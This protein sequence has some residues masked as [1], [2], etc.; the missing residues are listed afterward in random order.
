MQPRWN[1]PNYGE[2][3]CVGK[4][5]DLMPD[6]P[7]VQPV[8]TQPRTTWP[9]LPTGTVAR[10]ALIV[11]GGRERTRRSLAEELCCVSLHTPYVLPPRP[12]VVPRPPQKATSKFLRLL[13]GVMQLARPGSSL[14]S[15]TSVSDRIAQMAGLPS[16][17]LSLTSAS[18]F[19]T[20]WDPAH[21][22]KPERNCCPRRG[23]GG[24]R[25]REA[26]VRV[27]LRL[28]PGRTVRV[29]WRS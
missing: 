20:F 26:Q 1:R 9:I 12:V 13:A 7:S 2:T 8:P 3:K 15:L 28:T 29:G 6:R 10:G 19:R 5:P 18:D 27:P 11:H 17:F 14:F 24:K 4:R 21:P 23:P 22:A 25:A 16:S